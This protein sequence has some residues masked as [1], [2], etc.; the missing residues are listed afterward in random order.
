MR[1]FI[2][3][4]LGSTILFFLTGCGF[5]I[6]ESGEIN[7]PEIEIL[8]ISQDDESTLITVQIRAG[9]F[10]LELA[11]VSYNR[12]ENFS[13]VENQSLYGVTDA[14][15]YELSV[16]GL[17]PERT[18]YFRAFVGED[19]AYAESQTV[20]FFVPR[21][22][23]PAIPCMLVQNQINDRG[24][25]FNN[26]L[27]TTNN[28]VG[29]GSQ[30]G[31]R[32]DSGIGGSIITV[33]F[34]NLPTSGIYQTS[35]FGGLDTNARNV[36]IGYRSGFLEGS[37]QTGQSVYVEKLGERHYLVSFCDMRYTVSG[38]STVFTFTGQVE[39]SG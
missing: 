35:T 28:G 22:V 34:V 15:V 19:S 5:G 26:P 20:S 10:E 36:Y 18:Y 6:F 39:V 29:G 32:I 11:G 37:I 25:T 23:A 9:S 27:I 14:G 21:P 33:G 8:S 3:I 7:S 1:L 31:F 16:D 2:S 38:S 12:E 30:Y 4:L 24:A 17:T 13:I